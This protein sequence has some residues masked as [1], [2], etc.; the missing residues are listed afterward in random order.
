MD[1]TELNATRFLKLGQSSDVDTVRGIVDKVSTRIVPIGPATFSHKQAHI[2]LPGLDIYLTQA[3]PRFMD[4]IVNGNQTYVILNMAPGSPEEPKPRFNGHEMDAPGIVVGQ[5]GAAF[6]WVEFS[7]LVNAGLMFSPPLNDRGWPPS[8]KLFT[9]CRITQEALDNVRHEIRQACAMA[10]DLSEP[11]A[12]RTKALECYD[13]IVASI[14]AAF[15]TSQVWNNERDSANKRLFELVESV[16]AIFDTRIAMPIY[17]VDLANELNT[18]VKTLERAISRYRS[19]SLHRYIKVKRL[20]LVRDKLVNGGPE[21]LIKTYALAHGFWHLGKF[22]EDYARHFGE[23][24][25]ETLKKA[26]GAR[27]AMLSR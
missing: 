3:F 22:S 10:A 11:L 26:I 27:T 20:W 23:S 19:M 18:S 12:D 15:V 6:K 13:K 5:K 4:T 8:G 1:L 17:T 14:D 25:S 21:T 2:I 9:T 16:D 24:P 7:S